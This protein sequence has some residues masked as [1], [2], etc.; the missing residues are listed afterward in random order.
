MT[1]SRRER[2]IAGV[3]VAAL[4]VLAGDHY[5]AAPLL[6]SRGRLEADRLALAVDVARNTNLIAREKVVA[7][8]WNEMLNSG[9]SEAPAD[10]ESRTL[11]A[12]R[13]WAQDSGVSLASVRP[14]RVAQSSAD[15]QEE[16]FQAAGS[17]TMKAVVQFLWQVEHSSL[18]LRIKELQL[19]LRKEGVDDLSLQLRLSTAYVA[20]A[21]PKQAE[22]V[23][24]PQR[25]AGE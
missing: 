22:A 3:A 13:N 15:L 11:R 20:A 12:L 16:S 4:V 1:L 21:K 7:S 8:K 23:P 6:E 24:R 10:A 14:E 17:G 18:P 9:L 19:G 5:I 25:G 2:Y